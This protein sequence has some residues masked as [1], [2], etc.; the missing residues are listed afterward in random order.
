VRRQLTP[1]E[2]KWTDRAVGFR[3]VPRR[4]TGKCG[5]GAE[6]DK[7]DTGDVIHRSGSVVC[8]EGEHHAIH[9]AQETILRCGHTRVNDV[10][11]AY[12]AVSTWKRE[13]VR[14]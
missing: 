14:A 7:G 11:A 4:R 13:A 9:S 3:R 10:R 5:E 2:R 12:G 1:R 8:Q 6:S